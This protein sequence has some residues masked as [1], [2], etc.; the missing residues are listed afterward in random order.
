MVVA[1]ALAQAQSPADLKVLNGVL[2][3]VLKA[4]SDPVGELTPDV[5]ARGETAAR[6]LLALDQPAGVSGPQ[7]QAMRASGYK[8]LG[9]VAI[10]H[11]EAVAAEDAFIQSLK[12][13]PNDATISYELAR[14]MFIREN[15]DKQSLAIYHL[16]RA[17]VL[18]EPGALPAPQRAAANSY[19]ASTYLAYHGA[20]PEG[21]E[22]LKALA[23][24]QAIPPSDFTISFPER[25]TI[26]PQAAKKLLR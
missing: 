15:R 7:W 19:L 17:A 1:V 23:K 21:L 18:D 11:G 25:K 6:E 10:M 9:W 4:S 13:D 5:L 24:T 2:A 3:T 20:D 12:L 22:K 26:A 14:A 8:V 16:A